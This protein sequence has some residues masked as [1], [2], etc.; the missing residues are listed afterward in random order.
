MIINRSD[1]IDQLINFSQD[2]NGVII[3]KPGIGKSY[4]IAELAIK[5]AAL[6]I[7]S[8]ILPIDILPDGTNTSIESFIECKGD[9]IEYLDEIKLASDTHKAVLIFDA[10]DSARDE[11]LRKQILKQIGNSIL[12]LKKWNVLVSVR[13]YDAT[14]S[15]Q[16][17]KLFGSQN[18]DSAVFCRNFEISELTNDELES[19]FETEAAIGQLYMEANNEFK[20][21]LRTP[22][23][24]KLLGIVLKDIHANELEKI[25][26]I[27]SEIEL[28][29]MYWEKKVT[30]TEN[31][32]KKEICLSLIAN[33]LVMN[34]R[35]NYLK[36]DLLNDL[37]TFTELRSD[38]LIEEV[39]IG[40]RYVSFS[41]NIL[42]DYVISRLI[43]PDDKE[44]L[45]EFIILD[46]SR[47]FFLR[48]SFIYHFTTLW[49]YRRELFWAN[50]NFLDDKKEIHLLLFRRLILTS[51]IAN[52]FTD[53][54]DL[55]PIYKS[56]KHIQ[57]LLQSIRF[58]FNKNLRKRNL[59][60][61]YEL[62][63]ELDLDLM[64]DYAFVFE[65]IL[66]SEEIT[67][68]ESFIKC[69]IISR[70]FLYFILENRKKEVAQRQMLD[71]I[72]STKGVE[73]V[74]K[75]FISNIEESKSL[76]L[77][78][79][80]FLN[81]PRFEIWYFTS[82]S[83]DI[84]LFD[85]ADPN[86]VSEIYLRIYSHQEL[87]GEKTNMGTVILN[88]T[89]NRRQDF[90]MC[91]YRL[92]QFFPTFLLNSP[93][94]A[95]ETGLKIV[96]E[97]VKRDK[98][99][100][101]DSSKLNYFDIKIKNKSSLL[102]ADLS[103]IW[104]ESMSSRNETQLVETIVSFFKKMAQENSVNK[105]I[106]YIDI[107]I[108]YAIVGYTWKKLLEFLN[109]YP[110]LMK[111]YLYELATNQTIL[112]SAETTY[113]IGISI[114]KVFKFLD[115]GQ[116]V[117]LEKAIMKLVDIES[118]SESENNFRKRKVNRLLNCI[119]HNL[120]TTPEAILF[121]ENAEVIQ[122]EP[123]FKSTWSSV[124]YTTDIWLEEQGVDLKDDE[125][126]DFYNL[127]SQLESFN[128]QFINGSP[129][130]IDFVELLPIAS[131]L[132]YLTIGEKKWKEELED[133]A[134]KEIS[135][136]YSI[137]VRNS[138]QIDEEDYK[139][140]KKAILFG[141]DYNSK[142]DKSF[143]D[144]SSPSSGYSPTPR[145]EASSGLIGLF[146]YKNEDDILEKIKNVAKDSNPI[147]RFSVLRNVAFL[148]SQNPIEYWEIVFD[149]LINEKDSFTLATVVNGIYQEKIISDEKNVDKSIQIA[150]T[151]ISEFG[152][153]DSFTEMYVTVLLYLFN[154]GNKIAEKIIYKNIANVDFTQTLVFKLFNF[155][156]PK[157]V[158]N[159]Y[160]LVN[161][162]KE[163][164]QLF[165]DIAFNN[166][167]LLKNVNIDKFS[168]EKSLE[169]ERL[170]LIDFI[171]QR[172][173][174][175]L[176]IN[177]RIG[178]KSDLKPSDI[179]KMAFYERVKP[180]IVKIVV[181]SKE[182]GG[183]V[184]VA[185]TAHY[186]IETFNG[187]IKFYPKEAE[188]ILDMTAQITLMAFKVGYSFDPSSIKEI[189]NLTEILFAD[190]KDLLRIEKCMDQL[191][192]I[193]NIY[194]E[195]GWQQALELLWRI[196]EA[197]K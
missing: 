46:K 40:Q 167:E 86:F 89:S 29:E 146:C 77:E 179:N 136:F 81:E 76:F 139:I 181:D 119:P 180:I 24:L 16:L 114:N 110:E 17:L 141:L 25:K 147:V 164:I 152:K 134:I 151:R 80:N 113:E 90:E 176:N 185:H 4:S 118:E 168:D 165:Q 19:A 91:H 169:R 84:K 130:R 1:M 157:F 120:I 6:E 194:V 20:S 30:N 129:N 142:Y 23:F 92:G 132:F 138:S 128:H 184:M 15:P 94:I 148:W 99:H 36:A 67:E 78:I 54:G 143:N 28:L 51:V 153:R 190:H 160:T 60:F 66:Q 74:S 149:R 107:Y 47:P 65:S 115:L 14:K 34:R 131:S 189:V 49:H 10:F 108:S 171:I 97:F 123:T 170:F 62:S 150:S 31:S 58:L 82:L 135:K 53:V 50:Y 101:I 83:D 178:K 112:E 57:Q 154:R 39:G 102:L 85:Q 127:V 63:A 172:I 42:F 38:N 87:S 177:E 133:S 52:E 144:S 35:L 72:G 11:E 125:N 187:V 182:I 2:G 188:F 70:R 98:L 45:L 140:A 43:I 100:M 56:K 95:I 186:L 191:I 166:I 195:C 121:L 109:D 7:P 64:W 21:F 159:D 193:L 96:N 106:A 88:L 162:K 158:D 105:L 111:E 8:V 155:I 116:Q 13:T 73:F 9:W 26:L 55:E 197:F 163:L 44:K 124:P 32:Y 22:Y 196:D 192:S 183:G 173:Y 137:I 161:T 104:H 3:G 174:F 75:T 156:D 69:G 59:K 145:I 18:Y 68:S 33:K 117:Y 48:P 79:L 71:R 5:L 37:D 41:H 175:G 61:L 12:R 93:E 103:S 126:H 122:N 27:K